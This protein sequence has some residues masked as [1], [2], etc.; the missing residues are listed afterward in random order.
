MSKEVSPFVSFFIYINKQGST[1][2]CCKT[3]TKKTGH[4]CGGR[5]T[6]RK[7]RGSETIQTNQTKTNGLIFLLLLPVSPPSFAALPHSACLPC[8]CTFLPRSLFLLCVV[9]TKKQKN[10]PSSIIIKNTGTQ[11]S[12]S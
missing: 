11:G 5:E 4:T 8:F 12:C 10:E 7:T 1:F 9:K 2:L 3:K 6:E